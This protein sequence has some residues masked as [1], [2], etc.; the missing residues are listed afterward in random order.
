M[1]DS[2]TELKAIRAIV[3]AMTLLE[4]DKAAQARVLEYVM[5]RYKE[6]KAA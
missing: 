6:T 1:I 2:K 5:H 3:K 4:I